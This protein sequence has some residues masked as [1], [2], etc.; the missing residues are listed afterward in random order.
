MR[1]LLLLFGSVAAAMRIRSA[2]FPRGAASMV[3]EAPAVGSAE[4]LRAS[5]RYVASNR[6]RVKP[7]PRT[8]AESPLATLLATSTAL[9]TTTS[10][11]AWLSWWL[12]THHHARTG[13][14]AA[15]EK[16]WADR[17]SRLGLLDGFP[18]G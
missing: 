8:R 5:E 16:R 18:A 13:R 6:F 11:E 10:S 2:T 14:E 9:T 4:G 7:G 15:F 12:L 1:S 3:A 17:K